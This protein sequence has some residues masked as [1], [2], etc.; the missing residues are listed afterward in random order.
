MV[1]LK[2][3]RKTNAERSD[4]VEIALEL[5]D[6]A[7]AEIGVAAAALPNVRAAKGEASVCA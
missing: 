7:Q 2:Q 4:E 1:S 5:F 3:M 6:A